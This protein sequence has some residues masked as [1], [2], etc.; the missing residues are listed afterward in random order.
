MLR[1]KVSLFGNSSSSLRNLLLVETYERGR[2]HPR[3]NIFVVRRETYFS[4]WRNSYH[5]VFSPRKNIPIAYVY[6]IWMTIPTD[7]ETYLFRNIWVSTWKDIHL[8]FMKYYFSTCMHA[9]ILFIQ[10]TIPLSNGKSFAS[11]HCFN[12]LSTTRDFIYVRM[13]LKR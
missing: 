2:S 3:N 1:W 4:W 10:E 13:L 11:S 9:Y 6:R 5:K 7:D 8:F 12:K